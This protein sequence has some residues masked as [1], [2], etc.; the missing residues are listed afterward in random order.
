MH[1]R[2]AFILIYTSHSCLV[3]R[4]LIARQ[5]VSGLNLIYDMD[6]HNGSDST[7]TLSGKVILFL[8]VELTL[9]FSEKLFKEMQFVFIKTI[10]VKF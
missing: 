3:V 2:F 4:T 7:L 6:N 10:K 8:N 9:E 5:E 1:I